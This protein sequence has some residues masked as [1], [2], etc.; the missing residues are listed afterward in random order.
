M[1]GHGYWASCLALAWGT[2]CGSAGS[3]LLS[4][5][6]A[7]QGVDLGALTAAPTPGELDRIR[8][9]WAE[10]LL[11]PPAPRV[12]FERSLGDGRRLLVVEHA[13]PAGVHFG[14]VLLPAGSPPSGGY[15]MISSL[16]GYGPPFEVVVQPG[17]AREGRIEAAVLYPALR[18]MTLV[19]DG[20]RYRADGDRSDQCEGATEDALAFVEAVHALLPDATDPGRQVMVGGSRGGNVALLAAARD[21]RVLG[22]VSLAGPSNY[23]NARYLDHPN[24]QVLY[25]EGFARALLDG[26]GDADAARRHMLACSPAWF[27]SS[28][29]RAQHHHGLDDQN[30][31]PEAADEL[32]AGF[33]AVEREG[34]LEV[35]LY[36]EAD[37]QF[38]GAL[39]R[40]TESVDRFVAEQLR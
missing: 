38:R 25:R 33:A 27:A 23:L 17:P 11:P 30:V 12:V 34:S 1:R 36:P 5:E 21:P 40:V 37:H 6:L 2:G 4:A 16:P 26:G 39:E 22:A 9:A 14:A 10:R 35:L 29:A 20:V 8:A 3:G 18:G 19:V 24:M 28:I 13:G 32:R 7:A 15:P 31:P